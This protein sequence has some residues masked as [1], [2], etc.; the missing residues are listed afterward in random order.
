MFQCDVNRHKLTMTHDSEFTLI[1]LQAPDAGR[2]AI[3]ESKCFSDGWD[4]KQLRKQ[5]ESPAVRVW[6]LESEDG[7]LVGYLL[8]TLIADEM[9]IINIGV[10]P[11]LRRKGLGAKLLEG[12]LEICT[13][14]G[15]SVGF[16][17]VRPSNAAAI[18]LYE[19]FGFRKAGVRKGYYRDTGED[20]LV[21]RR[22]F[23]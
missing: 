16:L 21:F 1:E 19:K 23:T 3:L 6:G 18:A 7:T 20:G 12:V 4:E 8:I 14:Y 2:L 5:L 17:D 11:E 9:E 13:D 15:V 10:L 22:E